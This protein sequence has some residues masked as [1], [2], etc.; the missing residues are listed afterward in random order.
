[1]TYSVYILLLISFLFSV[2]INWFPKGIPQFVLLYKAE[3]AFKALKIMI[4]K[5]GQFEYMKLENE[6]LTDAGVLYKQ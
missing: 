1:M 4:N 2:L 6:T 3:R 5:W